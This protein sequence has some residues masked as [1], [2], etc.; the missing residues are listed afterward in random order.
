M[1]GCHAALLALVLF[2]H[3]GGQLVRVPNTTLNLPA[4]LPS[5]TEYGTENALDELVFN[6]P[7]SVVSVRHE[8]HRLF[9]AERGGILK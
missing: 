4:A 6:E 8:T 5:A 2:T 9:V 7:M 3:A 1:R